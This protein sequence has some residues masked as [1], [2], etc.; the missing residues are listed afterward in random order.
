MKDYRR[1]IRV[2]ITEVKKG[3]PLRETEKEKPWKPEENECSNHGILRTIM[4]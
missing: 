1:E 4:F 2:V 3:E